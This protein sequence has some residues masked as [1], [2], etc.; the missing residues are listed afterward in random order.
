MI[1]FPGKPEPPSFLISGSPD[2]NSVSLFWLP[3][4]HGDA[5]QTFH[6]D[7]RR[8]NGSW[9]KGPDV[10][11]EQIQG[12]LFNVTV[13]DLKSDTRY[14]FRI[15]ASSSLGCRDLFKYEVTRTLSGKKEEFECYDLSALYMLFK[16]L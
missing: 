14:E 11:G 16:S 9:V 4:Y 2:T 10:L 1:C 8:V 13:S 12:Q 3:G 6:I 5:D 7:F 15:S